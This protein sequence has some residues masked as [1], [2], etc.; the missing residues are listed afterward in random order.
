MSGKPGSYL[1]LMR[2]GNCFMASFAALIG[3]YI[4][5]NILFSTGIPLSFP[6]FSGL[7][8]FLTV[9]FVTGA[10]NGMNDYFDVEID[11]VNK[12]SRPIPSGRIKPR[13][14]LAFSFF[15][16]VSGIAIA[17]LV[18]FIC[19]LIALFNSLIL[20]YYAKQLKKTPF[21]GN[22][23]VGY[24]TGSTFL[25]GAAAFGMEGLSALLVLFILASLATIAREIVKDV[26]DM[27]GDKKD[28]ART[29]P[30]LIGAKKASYVAVSFGLMAMLASPLPY[31]Q[32]LLDIRYLL[33]VSMAN[34][35][36]II[37]IIEILVRNDAAGSSKMFKYAMFFALISFV[38]GA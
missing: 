13:E 26:E 32:G 21:F 37:A 36:F 20:I 15:L 23:C 12:P 1:E 24:L 19:G 3:M 25:F 18:N 35:F 6:L 38:A 34:I 11:R 22:V 16:L 28:G 4:T 33:L 27:E 17:F 8:V 29:L 31:L 30:I 5:Y 7:G 14:A 2:F 9:L 10:G